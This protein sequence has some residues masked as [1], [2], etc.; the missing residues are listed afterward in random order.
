M[1]DQLEV[2]PFHERVTRAA[3]DRVRNANKAKL[4]GTAREIYL[5]SI[6]SLSKCEAVAE[7]GNNGK[8]Y[9]LKTFIKKETSASSDNKNKRRKKQKR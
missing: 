1:N 9:Y 7:R 3:H 5:Q 2:T 6:A 4:S 8:G